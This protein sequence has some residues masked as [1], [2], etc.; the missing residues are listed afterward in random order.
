MLGRL[1]R[2]DLILNWPVV[3][4]VVAGIVTFVLIFFLGVGNDR[5][6][7]LPVPLVLVSTTGYGSLMSSLFAA[8]D[9]RFR[10]RVFDLGL[11]VPPGDVILARYLIGLLLLPLWIGLVV[12]VRWACAGP[13]FPLEIVHPDNLVLALAAFVA[14]MGVVFPLVV[15]VGFRGLLYG[16][17]GLQVLG[18]VVVVLGRRFPAV[19]DAISRLGRIAPVAARLRTLLGDAGCVTVATGALLALYALSYAA[20]R[21]LYRRED[22]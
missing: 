21:A 13:R 9:T 15:R 5:G 6:H 10:T 19:L 18:L 17:V 1:M 2:K 11:P 4:I 12:V 20:A 14:G 8:R 3:A 7:G 16:A 22:A